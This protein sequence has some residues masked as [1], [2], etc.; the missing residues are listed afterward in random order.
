MVELYYI[1]IDWTDI[2]F[3][4][5]NSLFLCVFVFKDLHEHALNIQLHHSICSLEKPCPA[6]AAKSGILALHE[7]SKMAGRDLKASLS[8]DR[9]ALE[10]SANVWDLM[11]ALWGRLPEEEDDGEGRF[12]ELDSNEEWLWKSW[13]QHTSSVLLDS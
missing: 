10:H 4:M 2:D 13:I 5:W 8:R 9:E 12:P 6:Y 11:V 7:Q 1:V 3:N